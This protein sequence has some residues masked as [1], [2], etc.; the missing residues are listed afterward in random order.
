ASE[1]HPPSTVLVREN[2]NGNVVRTDGSPTHPAR[3][4]PH[5]CGT[6]DTAHTLQEDGGTSSLAR[7][8]PQVGRE[9]GAATATRRHPKSHTPQR[10]RITVASNTTERRAI[11][12]FM[13]N[14]RNSRGTKE[15]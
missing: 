15:P 2:N 14:P 3:Y 10:R 12:C 6:A 13:E 11:A 4:G 5:P 9:F 7:T 1:C 8:N